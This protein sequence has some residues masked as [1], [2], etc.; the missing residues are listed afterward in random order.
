V[1]LNT[2]VSHTHSQSE[3]L[4]LLVLHR[5]GVNPVAEQTIMNR[6]FSRS[7]G[8]Q[9]FFITGNILSI[10]YFSSSHFRL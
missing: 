5:S 10:Q 3:I 9:R 6:V 8:I 7:V 2:Q 4:Q 1:S